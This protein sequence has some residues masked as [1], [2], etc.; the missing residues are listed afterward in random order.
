M[1]PMTASNAYHG[2]NSM[3]PQD[4]F[5]A[6]SMITKHAGTSGTGAGSWHWVREA[7]RYKQRIDFPW[8]FPDN[9]RRN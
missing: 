6:A 3:D 1:K 2:S 7:M 5:A 9:S 4:D 8:R